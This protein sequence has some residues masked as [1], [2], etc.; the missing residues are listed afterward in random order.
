MEGAEPSVQ[1]PLFHHLGIAA[2]EVVL[3]FAHRAFQSSLKPPHPLSSCLRKV[4]VTEP[5]TLNRHQF[6]INIQGSTGIDNV[7][8][9]MPSGYQGN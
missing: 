6:S 7:A 1:C 2:S 4:S 8:L 3:D 9:T 5:Q